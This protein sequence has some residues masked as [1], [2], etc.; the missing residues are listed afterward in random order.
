MHQYGR[1]SLEG[2]NAAN[3]YSKGGWVDGGQA[4][5]RKN[6]RIINPSAGYGYT[7]ADI[8]RIAR[9]LKQA[10]RRGNLWDAC[11]PA[12][13]DSRPSLTLSASPSGK[14]LLICRAGCSFDSIIRAFRERGLISAGRPDTPFSSPPPE[15]IQR[16]QREQ[17]EKQ[18]HDEER[19]NSLLDKLQ[20]PYGSPVIPYLQ[21]RGLP[22]QP[23]PLDVGF[24]PADRNSPMNRD[25]GAMV[26]LVRN[27]QCKIQGLHLTYLSDDGQ[28][29]PIKIQRRMLGRVSGNFVAIGDVWG[30][31]VVG[32][33]EGIETSMSFSLMAEIPVLCALSSSNLDKVSL[34][35]EVREVCLCIDNDAAGH[36]AKE[37]AIARYLSDGISVDIRVPLE[38]GD[39]NDVIAKKRFI[40]NLTI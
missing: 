26:A 3:H 29:A 22:A 17:D 12:H 31:P 32:I 7:Q 10:K 35:P 38:E 9:G 40:N 24:L 34:P 30:S 39:A 25:Y 16:I 23:V 14:I 6:T 36:A 4:G 19:I 20:S 2:K 21:S 8:D 33:A 37:R 11:C 28:K 1:A 18:Q 27:A 15:I 5:S 13:R